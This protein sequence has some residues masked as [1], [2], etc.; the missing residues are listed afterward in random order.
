MKIAFGH[1]LGRAAVV[2]LQL[3]PHL[4]QT[5]RA[6]PVFE[7]AEHPAAIDA[8]QLPVVADQNEFG[9]AVIGMG[10]QHR[11][12]FGVDHCGLVHHDD[13]A[14]VPNRAP[15][16]EGEQLAMDRAGMAEAVGLHVLGDG[17][18]RREPD[19]A[20]AP[21]LIDLADRGH[22]VALAGAGL[23]VDQR[24]APG[25]GGLANGAGLLARDGR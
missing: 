15:I 2:L 4:G 16:I 23:A 14:A 7:S 9:A 24:E 8:R 10:G 5:C 3:P 18:G 11:H 13:G 6:V 12:E 17:V 22:R 19:H 25:L 21:R 1:H 20:V